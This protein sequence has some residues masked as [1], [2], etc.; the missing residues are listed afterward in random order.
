M[1]KNGLIFLSFISLALASWACSNTREELDKLCVKSKTVAEKTD[2]CHQMAISLSPLYTKFNVLVE[3]L[4]QEPNS[5]VRKTY[6]DSVS[7]CLR[8]FLEIQ[9]GTCGSDPE[10]Q[11]IFNGNKQVPASISENVLDK[12][13]VK[14]AHF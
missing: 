6:V 4:N 2:D 8:S 14:E 7:R 12:D 5:D 11:S 1:M 13:N 3:Q 10:I 9:T